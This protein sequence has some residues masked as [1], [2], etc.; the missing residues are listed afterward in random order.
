VG[1]V[2]G[3]V[4]VDYTF[5][6]E[7]GDL[8]GPVCNWG[9]RSRPDFSRERGDVVGPVSGAVD[10]DYTLVGSVGMWWDRYLGP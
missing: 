3:A 8:V 2:T 10:L 9:C 4:G 1:P 6:R 5:S 7:H